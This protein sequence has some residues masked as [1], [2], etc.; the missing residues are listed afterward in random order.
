[1]ISE[2]TSI[3]LTNSVLVQ[4]DYVLELIDE[5]RAAIPEDIHHAQAV[6]E[7]R[8]SLLEDARVAGQRLR[9]EAETQF[10]ARLDEHE[11]ARAARE[12][13]DT[14]IDQS[15]KHAQDVLARAEQEVAARYQELDE[16]SLSV[17][18]RLHG[19]LAAQVQSVQ[20]GIDAIQKDSARSHGAPKS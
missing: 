7:T 17:L 15:N 12:Q 14:I 16:Y 18:R 10:R 5:I 20:E 8:E 13:G 11:L 9:D 6:L 4:K 19:S 2:S 3:P 1:M